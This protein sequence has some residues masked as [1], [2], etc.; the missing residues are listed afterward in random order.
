MSSGLLIIWRYSYILLISQQFTSGC[1]YFL[2]HILGWLILNFARV[3]A[4]RPALLYFQGFITCGHG[5]RELSLCVWKSWRVGPL[6]QD[7][8]L[9]TL[10][11][12]LTFSLISLLISFSF[13]TIR[14]KLA[15]HNYLNKHL[16]A[17]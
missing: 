8:R 3:L 2:V 4:H 10:S 13:V 6:S 5:P 12:Q 14:N 17:I 9:F 16:L 1:F 15:L 7:Q 11:L